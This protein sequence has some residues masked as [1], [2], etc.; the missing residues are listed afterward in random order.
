MTTSALLPPAPASLHWLGDRAE[1]TG[2]NHAVDERGCVAYFATQAECEAFMQFVTDLPL[3]GGSAL[4]SKNIDDR[5]ADLLTKLVAAEQDDGAAHEAIMRE[6]L[7]EAARAGTAPP[8]LLEPY[9]VGNQYRMQGGGYV[10]FVGVTRPGSSY[11]CMYDEDGVHRYTRRDFGRVTGTPHY[12]DPRNTPPLYAA[13]VREISGSTAE[14]DGWLQALLDYTG[15]FYGSAIKH[16]MPAAQTA[17]AVAHMEKAARRLHTIAVSA[18]TAT[19]GLRPEDGSIAALQDR[20]DGNG[21]SC[22]EFSD[23]LQR[24]RDE[25]SRVL[26]MPWIKR[27]MPNDVAQE[28]SGARE[29]ARDKLLLSVADAV[30]QLIDEDGQRSHQ[31]IAENIRGFQAEM[32]GVAPQLCGR[33][34][35]HQDHAVPHEIPD[36]CTQEARDSGCTCTMSS[37]SSADIDPPEPQRNRTC[38]LHGWEPDPDA[39]LQQRRDDGDV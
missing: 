27:Y 39:A 15:G 24:I 8:P 26:G 31:L 29:D 16:G 17:D 5:L 34:A 10:R 22:K 32:V 19:S 12:T 11:E 28:G 20:A 36:A 18:I 35:R 37:V 23:S 30:V 25:A 33:P 4:S 38:P 14:A 21:R 1:A 13:P 9:V 6:A 3:P 7:E 2:T